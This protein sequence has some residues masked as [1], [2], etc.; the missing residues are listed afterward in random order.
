ML[1]YIY[2]YIY[3]HICI[4]IIAVT[5]RSSMSSST[6]RWPRWKGLA[7]SEAWARLQILLL[8]I[9]LL[10]I[11]LL[12]LII[13]IVIILT[14]VIMIIILMILLPANP[15]RELVFPHVFFS[16]SGGVFLFTDASMQCLQST[17]TR[18]PE[19]EPDITRRAHPTR[20]I[21]H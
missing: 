2:I 16:V 12:L 20:N 11:P 17:I 5:L 18:P 10:I 13:I 15:G 4:Y 6:R 9:P 7:P 3:L 14:S 8:I 1:I 19:S 21:T